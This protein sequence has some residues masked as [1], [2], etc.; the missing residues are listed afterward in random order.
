VTRPRVLACVAAAAAIA[1]GAGHLTSRDADA[2]SG[3]LTAC[4]SQTVTLSLEWGVGNF[5]W[6]VQGTPA[7]HYHRVWNGAGVMIF[8][9]YTA[10]SEGW[11]AGG[12]ACYRQAGIKRDGAASVTDLVYQF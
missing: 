1:V 9:S 8:N 3:Y 5:T 6:N 7:L 4:C 10:S 12:C 2:A 11:S